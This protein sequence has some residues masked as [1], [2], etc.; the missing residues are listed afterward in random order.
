[1]VGDGSFLVEDFINAITSQLDRVQDA[2][3]LKALNRP[4]TYALKDLAL[5]LKVFVEMDEQGNV[6][7]RTSGPNEAG[8]SVVNLGFTTITKPMIEENTISLAATRSASLDELGLAPEERQRLERVGVRN[9]A[10][11]TRLGASTGVKAV[12]RLADVSEDRLRQAL[13]RGQPRLSAVV[14]EAP[15]RPPVKSPRAQKPSVVTPPPSM[16]RAPAQVKVPPAASPAFEPKTSVVKIAPGTR[17]MNLIGANLMGA[18]GEP[19]VKLNS[20]TLT[21]AEAD[22]D[23]LVV[24]I[25][26]DF[27]GGALEVSLPNG[28]VVVYELSLDGDEESLEWSPDGAS[29]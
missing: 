2:L 26:Q 27:T 4:L 23:R 5:E 12:A 25:P 15:H 10:Q 14:P 29:S 16:A 1:M 18:D 19:T 21:I 7:F 11:L 9:L 17:R 22:S 13:A 3:R 8:A 6:R 24:D 20:Q 28:S